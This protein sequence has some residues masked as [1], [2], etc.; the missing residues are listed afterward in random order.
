[1][2][3]P[4]QWM[5]RVPFDQPLA[6]CSRPSCFTCVL[7]AVCQLQAQGSGLILSQSISGQAQ[8]QPALRRDHALLLTVVNSRVSL[9]LVASL[10]GH[11][12][13]ACY[14]CS[15]LARPLHLLCRCKPPLLLGLSHTDTH[16][17]KKLQQYSLARVHV[18]GIS[19][20][21]GMWH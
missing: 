5:V 18:R 7:H 2:F 14:M 16:A 11:S 3:E 19:P 8:A 9:F 20:N 13:A 21:V 17:E 15:R 12:A 6:S 1:M 10:L 4:V